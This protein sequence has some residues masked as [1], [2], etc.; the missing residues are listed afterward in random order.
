MRFPRFAARAARI[1]G[2]CLGSALASVVSFGVGGVLV[3]GCGSG[4]AAIAG[5]GGSGSGATVEVVP[6]ELTVLT[7]DDGSTGN[8]EVRYRLQVDAAQSIRLEDVEFSLRGNDANEFRRATS[9]AAFPTDLRIGEEIGGAALADRADE[10]FV[11]LWNSHFDLDALRRNPTGP[12]IQRP[13]TARAVLRFTVRNL[14]T[15]AV[16]VRTTEE[17]FLHH[18]LVASVVGG[19]VGDGDTP[20]GAS[21][22]SPTAIVTDVTGDLVLADTGNH[23]V[24]HIAMDGSQATRVRTLVGNGFRG[25]VP[26]ISAARGTSLT[27]PMALAMTS[28]GN[29]F[30]AEREP[31]RPGLLRVVDATSGLIVPLS[32]GFFVDV[33]A[34]AL[35]G[36]DMLYVADAT[37]GEV[38]RVDVQDFDPLLDGLD[39]GA[40]QLVGNFSEPVALAA[41]PAASPG[42][43]ERVYVVDRASRRV[44]RID[45]GVPTLA[46]VVGGGAIDPSTSLAQL[47]AN[48]TPGSEVRLFDPVAVAADARFLFVADSLRDFVLVLETTGFT[49]VNGFLGLDDPAG[50]AVDPGGN[51]IVVEGKGLVQ[52]GNAGNEVL[53]AEHPEVPGATLAPLAGGDAMIG[54]SQALDGV[55]TQ[56]EALDVE[57]KT[58]S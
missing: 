20:A 43:V 4:T 40:A 29:L 34:L 50:L 14:T 26:G 58:P 17:F 46:N 49:V 24:R 7:P 42:G 52:S 8:V 33:S 28:T 54:T 31:S 39:L 36:D 45:D 47:I 25:V 51:L 22:L 11:F 19:G 16:L 44:R 57:V 9:I 3:A 30:L 18:G 41:V 2:A 21:M 32:E 35:A 12:L 15:G 5:G 48:Q 55:A 1:T 23:R 27:E 56:I 10:F 37:F 38:W 13:V 6:T 53:F